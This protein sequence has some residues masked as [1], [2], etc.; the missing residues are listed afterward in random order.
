MTYEED[1]HV[2]ALPGFQDIVL[3]LVA[4]FVVESGQGFVQ[5]QESWFSGDGAGDGHALL[6]SAGQQ[7]RPLMLQGLE[8]H[9]FQQFTHDVGIRVFRQCKFQ[10]LPD[11]H[12]GKECEVLEDEADG[13]VTGG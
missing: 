4:H 13:S 7:G 3:E 2:V 5:E 9:K 6:L 10:L 8:V 1:G 12:I 11:G